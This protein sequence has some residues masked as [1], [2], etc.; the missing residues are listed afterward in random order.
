MYRGLTSVAKRWLAVAALFLVGACAST[1]NTTFNVAPGVDFSQYS[2]FGFFSPLATDDE[3]YESLLSNFLKVATAQQLDA[4]GLSY[5]D[6]PDL[7]INFYVHTQEKLRSRSYPTTSAYY[8][9]RDPF[10]YDPWIAYPT[11]ET[12]I[13]Q[14][15]QGTLN[16]D[17]VDTSTQKLVWEG[18]V[19]GRV[20]DESVRNLEAS[21]D[22][23][24][25]DIMAD[26]PRSPAG[27]SQ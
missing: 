16:I 7:K 23:A 4:R 10:F 5:S 22:K 13:D 9:Y 12:R 1:P 21:I 25:A 24:V 26:F 27:A 3:G 6:T 15:T 20:T 18:M 14:Y 11:Y 19:T 2:T 8:A 17:V